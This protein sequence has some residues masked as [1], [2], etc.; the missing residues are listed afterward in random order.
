MHGL[1]THAVDL[2]QLALHSQSVPCSERHPR[3]RSPRPP[4]ACWACS[5]R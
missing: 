3:T 4:A 5:R 2:G 1:V